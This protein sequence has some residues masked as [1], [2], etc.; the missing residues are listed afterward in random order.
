MWLRVVLCC[1]LPWR[2]LWA[3]LAQPDIGPSALAALTTGQ[4]LQVLRQRFPSIQLLL[5]H[6]LRVGDCIF[7]APPLVCLL[8]KPLGRWAHLLDGYLNAHQVTQNSS[9]K[10]ICLGHLGLNLGVEGMV[11]RCLFGEPICHL[12]E[13]DW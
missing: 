12:I 7:Y 11:L 10:L 1:I 5:E 13:K 2:R 3:R 4:A 8:S 6:V 9:L